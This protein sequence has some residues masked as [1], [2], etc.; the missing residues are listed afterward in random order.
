MIKMQRL[1]DS[2]VK[3]NNAREKFL[4]NL[5]NVTTGNISTNT[6]T[7]MLSPAEIQQALMSINNKVDKAANYE[8]LKAAQKKMADSVKQI[9]ENKDNLLISDSIA[10]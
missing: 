10:R 5:L 4:F 6:D 2:L 8:Y 9:Q 3:I 7:S 1:S